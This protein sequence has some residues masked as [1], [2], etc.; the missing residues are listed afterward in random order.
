M[1]FV[2]LKLRPKTDGTQ[3]TASLPQSYNFLF[4][5]LCSRLISYGKLILIKW[6]RSNTC[7]QTFL[8]L[9]LILCQMIFFKEHLL[10]ITAWL[11]SLSLPGFSSIIMF[12]LK[13]FLAPKH[14]LGYSLVLLCEHS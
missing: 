4:G 1:F 2:C 14:E 3:K 6:L 7:P 5:K 12:P 8:S 9:K 13:P 10:F 11:T